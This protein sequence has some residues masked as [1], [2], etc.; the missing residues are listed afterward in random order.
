MQ[1]P[2]LHVAPATQSAPLTQLVLQA[3]APQTYGAHDVVV[4]GLQ[5]PPPSQVP[6]P[7][8]MPPVHV[9]AAQTVDVDAYRQAPPEKLQ[10]TAPHTPDVFGHDETQHTP[11]TQKPLAH[12]VPMAQVLPLPARVVV[13]VD[14]MPTVVVVGG[15]V[16]VVLASTISGAHRSFDTPGN[17][18]RSP[19]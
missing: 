5:L 17:T 15:S 3:L 2:A 10:P 11:L 19:N 4:P 18:C 9:G 1:T 12:C 14:A 8:W 13:V 6:V 7:V 16:V